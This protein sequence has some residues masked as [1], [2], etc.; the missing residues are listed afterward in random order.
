LALRNQYVI[1]MP[2]TAEPITLSSSST[3]ASTECKPLLDVATKD[4]F[5]KNAFRITGLPVD[6]T[7]RDI[8]KHTEKLK[9]LAELGQDPQ[10]NAA[11]PLRSSPTVED[12]RDA[13][14]RLKD[15]EKRLIDEFFWFWPENFGESRTD[16]A[17]QALERGDLQKAADIWM[18]KRKHPTEGIVA[19][20]NLALIFL[21]EA[22]DCE[23]YSL[24]HEVDSKRR[25]EVTEYWKSAFYRWNR[26]LTNEQFW[27]KI[28]S[29]VRQLNEPN[30]TSGFVRR[31]RA[32]VPAALTRINADL[33]L[34]F[35]EAGK[36]EM[37]RL[38]T[39]LMGRINEAAPHVAKIAELVLTPAR[40][41]LQERVRHAKESGDKNPIE[42]IAAGQ[43]L[44]EQTRSILSL[45]D[46]FVTKNAHFR[47]D[48]FDEVAE[49][50]NVLQ[51]RYHKATNDNKS[52]L[53]FLKIVLPFAASQ[54]LQ[55]QIENNIRTL[56]ENIEGLSRDKK[57]YG[58]LQP[59][60]VAPSLF[61]FNGIGVTL[62]GS[63]DVDSA[64]GSYLSTYYFVF[65]F[66]PILPI[67]RYRVI[68]QG[69][70]Y[71]FLGKAP[72]GTFNKWHLAIALGIIGWF[73]ISAAI[74]GRSQSSTSSSSTYSP[75]GSG[76]HTYERPNFSDTTPGGNVAANELDEVRRRALANEKA[77]IEL[78]RATVQALDT[79]VE[80]L[81]REIERDRIY[82]DRT[83]QYQLNE[84]NAKV[85]R[86]NALLRQAQS[87]EAAF[88]QKVDE[89]NAKVRG[90][91]SRSPDENTQTNTFN[92]SR[93]TSS[94]SPDAPSRSPDESTQTNTFNSSGETSSG[95]A[96]A[97]PAI[98]DWA[99][100]PN[101]SAP[102]APALGTRPV[103]VVIS[104]N[105]TLN[106]RSEPS[107]DSN[108]VGKLRF[109]DHVYLDT[110][111]ELNT[112]GNPVIWQKITSFGGLEGWVNADYI[113]ATTY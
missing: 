72:L 88:N 35:A 77:Q 103:A 64:N 41:G 90:Y 12:I 8:G 29:R 79:D 74:S 33:A 52:C 101:V 110:G 53:E 68:R 14:Q 65:F 40:R 18:S 105:D 76:S 47:N 82:L 61:T 39:D 4:L 50:C 46:L 31:M 108:I 30:L 98:R 48:A 28:L 5:R 85:R 26:I 16:L 92:S 106:I 56:R 84:F 59:V 86:H 71:R 57:F 43:D 49:A 34:A 91:P 73:I 51:V 97:A 96:N 42:A 7:P 83:S 36:S 109:G 27:D 9:V 67:C 45:F 81:A 23:N 111:R 104:R 99:H 58:S 69:N 78:E 10:P 112:K 66:I 24:R 55:E 32:T 62:Y 15:P 13:I 107:S 75:D 113:S 11:F 44:L 25:A 95:S 3:Q 22:L 87:A 19:T 37:A 100:Q 17:I 102:A 80:N 6:A 94:S 1:T 89:Y 2:T 21:I 93:E 63:T 38:H 54:E 60:S 70:S 20:H